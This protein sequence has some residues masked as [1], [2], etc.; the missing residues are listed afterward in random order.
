MFSDHSV[1]KLEFHYKEK[2]EKHINTW[3]LNNMSLNNELVK[4]EIKKKIKSYL[5]INEN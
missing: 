2:A 4:I 3:R 1:M 5:E